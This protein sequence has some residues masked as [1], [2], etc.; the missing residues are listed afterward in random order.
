M[1]GVPRASAFRPRGL[2]TEYCI[3]T[4]HVPGAAAD[5]IARSPAPNS[6]SSGEHPSP[7]AER[8]GRFISPQVREG[9]G[10]RGSD[11]LGGKRVPHKLSESQANA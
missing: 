9:M 5:C 1:R 4:Y 10:T 3:S 6:F 2:F 11:K 8:G 7:A